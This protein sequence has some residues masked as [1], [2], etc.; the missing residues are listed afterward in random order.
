M[1][2]SLR[3]WL[4]RVPLAQEVDEEIA[5]H[6]EMRTRDLIDGGMDPARARETAIRR[7]GDMAGVKRT[8]VKVGRKRDRELSMA[9]WLEELRD[10]VIFA[11][12]QLRNAPIFALV[13]VTTLALGIGAN[14]ANAKGKRG[15]ATRSTAFAQELAHRRR[16]PSFLKLF[17]PQRHTRLPIRLAADLDHGWF[18]AGSVPIRRIAVSRAR[19]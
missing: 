1:K 19:G 17:Q 13:A 18:D 12:R 11:V 14:S 16:S 4:W 5:F 8:M 2:R 15:H 7:M 3:S 10:D 9:L 6:V